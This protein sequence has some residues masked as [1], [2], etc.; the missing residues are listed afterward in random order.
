MAYGAIDSFTGA[1]IDL[2]GKFPEASLSR[3][4]NYWYARLEARS[5]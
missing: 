2:A 3:A 5:S 4:W 1:E